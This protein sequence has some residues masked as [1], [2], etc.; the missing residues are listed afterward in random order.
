MDTVH[1]EPDSIL[2]AINQFAYVPFGVAEDVAEHIRSAIFVAMSGAD[3]ETQATL[4]HYLESLE[5]M[6]RIKDDLKDA[7]TAPPRRLVNVDPETAAAWDEMHDPLRQRGINQIRWAEFWNRPAP[8]DEW[9][10]K[11]LVPLGRQVALWSPAKMGK[12]LLALD[13]AAAL[14]TGKPLLGGPVAP[15]ASVVYIDQEMTPDDLQERLEDLGYDEDTDLSNLHYYQLQGI[16]VLDTLEGGE[17]LEAIVRGTKAH[18]VVLDT[19]ARVVAGEENIADT[20]RNFYKY[21]GWRLK[22]LGCSLLRL[23]HAGKDTAAGQRGSSAKVDDVD[24]VFQISAINKQDGTYVLRRTHS[25]IAWVE[26]SYPFT[27]HIKPM[28]WHEVTEG[29][30]YAAGTKTMADELDHQKVPIDAPYK[31]GYGRRQVFYSAQRFR[32]EQVG[33]GHSQT[34]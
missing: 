10:I 2:R 8:A 15:K 30:G 6:L 19:M 18:L 7:P 22:A 14:A 3:E 12:S 5:E 23:D 20:Y 26:E 33:D 11:P 31:R 32:R 24:V 34:S 27:R 16:P 1:P 4:D 9:L 13:A 29:L 28:L 21:A 17:V 25:R